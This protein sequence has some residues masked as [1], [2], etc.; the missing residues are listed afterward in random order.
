MNL[1]RS[2]CIIFIYQVITFVDGAAHAAPHFVF[3]FARLY[4]DVVLVAPKNLCPRLRN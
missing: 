3:R 1:T 4:R 2:P